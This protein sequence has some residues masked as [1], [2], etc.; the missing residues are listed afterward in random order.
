MVHKNTCNVGHG[1]ISLGQ[2]GEIIYLGLKRLVRHPIAFVIFV[3]WWGFLWSGEAFSDTTITPSFN[4]AT[5]NQ[6]DLTKLR[7]T[8]SN[9]STS[10]SLTNAAVTDLM[11]SQIV[12]SNPA[13]VVNTCGFNGV[14]A[15]PGTSKLVLTG[16]TVPIGTLSG[17]SQCYFEV[18]VVSTVVGNWV[19]TI[20]L[21]STPSNTVAGYTALENGVTIFDNTPS[22]SASATLSVNSVSAPSGTKSFSP[23]TIYAGE[24]STLSIVLSNPNSGVTMPLTTFT[25]SFPPGL[26]VA[27]SPTANVN[28]SG[29]GA[30]NGTFTPAAG[31]TVLSMTG[32]IIGNGGACTLTV[33]VI[34]NNDATLTN[35]VAAG[36]IGN[37]R[38]LSSSSF[39]GTLTANTPI[40]LSKSFSVSP[41]GPGQDSILILDITNASTSVPLTVTSITDT[42]PTPSN[43]ARAMTV[44]DVIATPPT[45]DCVSNGG[46]T[47][48]SFSPALVQGASAI[49]MV[50]AVVGTTGGT[51]RCR[52][53]VP[54]RGSISTATGTS[55]FNNTITAGDGITS[56]VINPG[57]F[58][59]PAASASLAVSTNLVVSKTIS[60]PPQYPGVP[61]TYSIAI[62]N[63]SGVDL[64]NVNI[65]DTL[66]ASTSVT[67]YQMVLANSV[68]LTASGACSLSTGTWTAN[69]GATSISAT[70]ITITRGVNSSTAGVCT[71]TFNRLWIFG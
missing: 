45:I 37:T 30:S 63:W 59:S 33:R 48:G 1:H 58:S 51:R 47:N 39:S 67:G 44:G 40:G 6:G 22:Q 60:N 25:D 52:I 10:Y 35:T 31:N 26:A 21:T 7:L 50:N 14:T 41:V 29:T 64:T 28:C 46:G 68:G 24:T 55:T 34:A 9:S 20:P 27:S 4:P 36:A 19:N 5:V 8:L 11:P 62:E 38:G 69:P 49:T 15:T 23:S 18:D 70:G 61:F 43:P 54:V 56:G 53:T 13:N 16:G 66:P 17:A 12:I 71:I 32:G 57:G 2:K 3:F 42:L 65:A